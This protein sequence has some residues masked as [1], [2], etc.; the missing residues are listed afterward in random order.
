MKPSE[1]VTQLTLKRMKE[2]PLDELRNIET[3]NEIKQITEMI[4][5][6]SSQI[7]GMMDYLDEEYE[8]TV[9]EKER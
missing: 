2:I 5:L 7:Q 6:I 1:R 3:T 9:W 8:K 4:V